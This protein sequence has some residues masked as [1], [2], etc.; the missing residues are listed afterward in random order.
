LALA[1][2][3]RVRAAACLCAVAIGGIALT[4]M[5][6]DSRNRPT[7]TVSLA[8]AQGVPAT[9]S[10]LSQALSALANSTAG[11]WAGHESASGALA[12]PVLGPIAGS[13][14][15]AMTGQAIVVAGVAASNEVLIGDGID[16]LLSEV[17]HPD[18]GG[19]ELLGVSEAYA[20]DQTALGGNPAWLLA[21]PRIARF[22]RDHAASISDLGACY[23]SPRCYT[24]LK[25]VSAVADLSLL[26]S[27]LHGSRR[28]ALL[29]DPTAVRKQAIAWLRM[30]VR[31]TG[32]D[33]Y[34]TGGIA[35]AGA[36]ILSDP[37]ENPLAYHALST[38]MLG[39][40]ILLLGSR[41]PPAARSAF[42]RTAEALV[43]LMAPDG[44]DTY[45]GRGQAQVWTV[46]ATIDALATAA[47]LTT[48]QTWRGR[49]L[50]AIAVAL[51]R[52]EALYPTSGW[53]FPL[54][55]RFAGQ[56]DPNNY[57]GIDHY[58][59]TVEYNGL[60]LW[61]L[62]DAAAQ[63]ENA[64]PAP[65]RTLPSLTNG[66]FVDP[67]HAQ[68]AA[69]TAGSLWFAIHAIDSNPGDGRYGFGL[70]AAELDTTSGWQPV[71]PARPLT[72]TRTIGGVAMSTD[73]R[74][75]YPI[76][77]A[78][79]ATASGKVTV[80][81]GWSAGPGGSMVDAGTVWIFR[82]TPAGD[83]VTLTFVAQPGRGYAFQVWYEPGAKLTTGNHGLTISEPDGSTQTCMLNAKV[84]LAR[85]QSDSSA[86]AA[87]LDSMIMTVAP[88]T[89]RRTLIY[90]TIFGASAPELGTT[91]VSGS[92]GGSGP[93]G[94]SG[95][96]G[97]S[98]ASGSS[99]PSGVTGA[100]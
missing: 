18:H 92:S 6:G 2:Y 85:G 36:G 28:R 67:S 87:S 77:R 96:S 12:D 66:A 83:G 84:H 14:G 10:D 55:P 46:A 73:A 79:S 29:S 78:I 68:F 93:S 58:A 44:D 39:K 69:V 80:S 34:R 23:T 32:D 47:E 17:A 56:A 97:P 25:L 3:T 19:F 40:A 15:V 16:A 75:L 90:T 70:V 61:A 45:I 59:N 43:A 72:R 20:F 37:T 38:L 9:P 89:S 82:P 99:D 49:Y 57:R 8:S 33:A 76:G 65:P 4:L 54:V 81:G 50:S 21:R 11:Q 95:S 63:L 98:G 88:S 74:T 53:G 48:S 41:T 42:A 94:A 100:S 60:A 22:L 7:L 5:H 13:Y 71:L 64:Q 91:G 86:Y 1:S 62:Q 30:A 26:R 27:G 51:E 52:L 35:F 24:N 31:N